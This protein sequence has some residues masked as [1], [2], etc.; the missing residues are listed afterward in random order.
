MSATFTARGE[1]IRITWG[2]LGLTQDI[3]RNK[4]AVIE[5]AIALRYLKPLVEAEP[6]CQGRWKYG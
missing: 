1:D 4:L 2:K 6:I 5:R 3:H